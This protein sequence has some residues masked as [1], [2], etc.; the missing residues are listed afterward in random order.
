MNLTDN[1]EVFQKMSKNYV[2]TDFHWG[3]DLDLI[4]VTIEELLILNPDP[5]ILD[6]A[7]G[8]GFHLINL[9][10]LYPEITFQGI[11]YS[12]LM[13]EK[14]KINRDNLN[15][16]NIII[17]EENIT[18]LPFD[19]KYDLILFLN[20]GYGNLYIKNVNP[21]KIRKNVFQK[22]SHSL[23]TRGRAIL[24]VYNL[25]RLEKNYGKELRLIED[26]SDISK[27]DL[28]V[29]YKYNNKNTPYYSHWFSEEEL[30][31]LERN[32]NLNIDFLEKRMSRF[33]VRFRKK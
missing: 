22:I 27:G 30:K 7:C 3:S 19:K 17:Q 6:L 9:A 14:A 13:L 26:K 21:K 25:E 11:D 28:F 20:N 5:A 10:Q 32:A 31:A 29:E 23:N 15:L 33:L 8:T 2:R 24:S 18:E 16:K 4:K 12:P 1:K